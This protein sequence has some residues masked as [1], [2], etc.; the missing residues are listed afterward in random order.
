[1]EEA[2]YCFCLPVH[3]EFCFDTLDWTDSYPSHLD[4]YS[5]LSPLTFASI[6]LAFA[7]NLTG[8]FACFF[9]ASRAH[10][11]RRRVLEAASITASGKTNSLVIRNTGLNIGCFSPNL[12]DFR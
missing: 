10:F 2:H 7:C 6:T 12:Q 4:P 5:P 11:G 1:M 8:A 9:A 3:S